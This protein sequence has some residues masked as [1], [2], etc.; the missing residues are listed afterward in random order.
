MKATVYSTKGEKVS[1][2]ELPFQF[3]EPIRADLIKRAVFSI[4]SH[5]RQIYAADPLAGTK[6]GRTESK[7]RRAFGGTYGKGISRVRR[8]RIWRRGSQMGW[9]GAFTANARKGRAAF[10]PLATKIFDEKINDKERRKAIRSAIAATADPKFL[11]NHKIS[12]VKTFPLVIE[13]SVEAAKKTKEIIF[14]LEKLGLSEEL[15][16]T[17]EKR[18]RAGKGKMR[19]RRYKKKVGALIVASKNSPILNSARNVPGL[20]AVDVHK[21]NAKLLAPSGEP[22]RLTLWTKSAIEALKKEELFK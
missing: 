4:N 10:P 21:L 9:I 15:D 13:D 2:I 6:Q 5:D 11:S 14:L 3:S 8:K 16:R 12:K 20:D 7:R 22:A 17:K 18:V 1:E 19:G